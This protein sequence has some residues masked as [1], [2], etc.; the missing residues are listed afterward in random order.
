[1]DAHA[2]AICVIT[3]GLARAARVSHTTVSRALRD[4]G[5]IIP[6]IQA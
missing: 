5:E 3:K 1:M 6:E 2:C 4:S